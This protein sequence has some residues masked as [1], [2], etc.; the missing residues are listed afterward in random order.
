MILLIL[1]A[2]SADKA[3]SG[4][5][6]R[7]PLR[8]RGKRQAQKMG[9][10]LGKHRLAPDLVMTSSDLRS[11][12]T[13]QKALKAA[14]W[15]ARDIKEGKELSAGC[16]PKLSGGGTKL[17]VLPGKSAEVL[18]KKLDFDPEVA[19]GVLYHLADRSGKI[20][21]IERIDPQ[22]LPGLFPYPAPDGREL[23]ERPAYYYTQSAV[24]PYRRVGGETEIL[25]VGSSS[26]R[27]W[28]VPKGIV[29]PGLDPAA[30]AEVEAREEAGIK[31]KVGEKPLG[32]FAYEKWGAVCQVSV[33]AMEVTDV[34]P[35]ETWEERHRCRKWVPAAS[36]GQILHQ[37]AFSPMISEI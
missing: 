6:S 10:W 27:H 35:D 28:V 20:C 19:P 3:F 34:I 4:P 22:D 24:I 36:A 23:R 7:R 26:G 8:T 32:T 25:I 1:C 17:L 15:T 9:A 11:K 12:V 14:G 37:P 33:Y 31:G 13:A 21:L 29:E 30:S 18:L 5:K 16:L 2:G